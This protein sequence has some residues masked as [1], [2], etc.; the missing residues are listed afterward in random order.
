[1][2]YIFDPSKQGI[3]H[4]LELRGGPAQEFWR[5]AYDARKKNSDKIYLRGLIEFS[6]ICAKDCYYCGIRKSNNLLHR[7]SL[8]KEEVLRAAA[9]AHAER[10]GSVTLQSG[11]ICA[12]EFTAFVE[13]LVKT[14]RR[15]F[16]LKIVLSCG[17]QS[18]ETY[19]VWKNAGADRYLL[20]IE[21]SSPRLY[22]KLHPDDANHSL[23]NRIRCL[24]DLKKLGYQTGSGIMAGLPKQTLSDIAGDLLF[25][26]ETDVDMCG[27]GTYIEHSQT[28]LYESR[29]EVPSYENRLYMTLNAIAALRL[30]MPDINIA[31]ATSLDALSPRGKELAVSAGANVIML[32]LTPQQNR[33][34]YKLYERPQET[35]DKNILEELKKYGENVAYG[36]GGDS[37]RF[38]ARKK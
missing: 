7:F 22:A 30:L 24:E 35:L 12:P 20:K 36:Q 28:P 37:E 1:M 33:P 5:Q 14:I 32:N 18:F 26:K 4:A 23:A 6:N 25:F 31:A 3:I 29:E 2:T 21:T 10:M 11:E 27:M 19:R 9:R 17:E 15:N 13:D 34:D 8:E 38:T 16:D